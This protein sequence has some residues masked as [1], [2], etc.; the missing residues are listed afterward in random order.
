MPHDLPFPLLFITPHPPLS[1]DRLPR[2]VEYLH[3]VPAFDASKLRVSECSL[4]ERY[5]LCRSVGDECIQVDYSLYPCRALLKA[6]KPSPKYG[7]RDIFSGV[8]SIGN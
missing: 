1:P 8:W 7:T 6:E 5:E 3:Q 2:L 4:E